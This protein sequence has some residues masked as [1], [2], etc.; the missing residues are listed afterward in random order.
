MVFVLSGPSS[1]SLLSPDVLKYLLS[2]LVSCKTA[3]MYF[4]ITCLRVH[5]CNKGATISFQFRNFES[6]RWLDRSFYLFFIQKDGLLWKP[7]DHNQF[8]KQILGPKINHLITE[9]AL[10]RNTLW[11]GQTVLDQQIQFHFVNWYTICLS[12][13]E[14]RHWYSLFL[15]WCFHDC[16]CCWQNESC[17]P[18]VILYSLIALEKFAQ[19]SKSRIHICVVLFSSKLQPINLKTRKTGHL[20]HLKSDNW[21]KGYHYDKQPENQKNVLCGPHNE[22]HVRYSAKNNGRKTG[23][24]TRKR[25]TKTN[26]GRLSKRLDWLEK[27]QPDKASLAEKRYLHG[28]GHLQPAGGTQQWMNGHLPLLQQILVCDNRKVDTKSD[29]LASKTGMLWYCIKTS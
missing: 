21:C 14:C 18:S 10:W 19:T 28:G 25:E 5:K 2:N 8:S 16:F 24:Q 12:R 3:G 13:R 11:R 6:S 9:P 29:C 23:R 26:M 1:I 17:R 7:L 27:I 4:F 15:A 20:G 22:K